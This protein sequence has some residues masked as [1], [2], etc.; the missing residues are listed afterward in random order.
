MS[1]SNNFVRP[2][3][4]PKYFGLDIDGTFH[5]FDAKAFEK[6]RKAF[7]KMME[8][9]YVP[10]CCTGM[11][12]LIVSYVCLGRPLLGTYGVL[13]ELYSDG[14]YKG[15][16]G[17]YQN[18]AAVYNEH[19]DLINAVTFDKAFLRR[20]CAIIEEHDLRELAVFI[21][22]SCVYTLS[23]E[24]ECWDHIIGIW[25][26]DVKTE[27]V[28]ADRI[29]DAGIIQIILWNYKKC[30]PYL[31]FTEGEDFVIKHGACGLSDINPPG[32]TKAR[33]IAKLLEC[34]GVNVSD[35]GFIGDGSNDIEAMQA[36]NMSF[37]VG[38]ASDEVKSHAKYV[39]EETNEEG[40]FAKAISLLYGITVD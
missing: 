22:G 17:V 8:A 24:S 35:C 37:A 33:G 29:V 13:E 28:S 20:F 18:G 38:N 10:F 39:L 19:G 36:S 25:D 3:T 9:G 7:R 32:V 5:A 30:A 11:L 2:T 21:S 34:Q 40:A 6:N 27:C 26:L 31:L 15:F 1:S 16:P 4:P 23:E 12:R 14:V